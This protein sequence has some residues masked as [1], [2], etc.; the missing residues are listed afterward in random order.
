M[1]DQ[2]RTFHK[3]LYIDIWIKIDSKIYIS[4]YHILFLLSYL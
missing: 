4:R 2:P 1:L 3:I